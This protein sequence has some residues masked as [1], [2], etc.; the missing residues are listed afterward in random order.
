M[1]TDEIIEGSLNSE[2]TSPRAGSAATS[3]IP[4]FTKNRPA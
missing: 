1:A 2:T 3:K 4:L